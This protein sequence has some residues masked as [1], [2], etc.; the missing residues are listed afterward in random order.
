M[1]AILP[2]MTQEKIANIIKQV[3]IEPGANPAIVSYNAT[4][5]LV[6]FENKTIFF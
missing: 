1:V 2:A 4:S 3:R 6:R 5:N